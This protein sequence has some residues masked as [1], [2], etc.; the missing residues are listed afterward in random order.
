M[1]EGLNPDLSM[2]TH[3][4]NDMVEMDI[5]YIGIFASKQENELNEALLQKLPDRFLEMLPDEKQWSGA[6]RV[7]D[8]ADIPGGGKIYLNADSVKQKGTVYLG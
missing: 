8:G 3:F 6:I 2:G 4:F 1:H 5:L 7:I